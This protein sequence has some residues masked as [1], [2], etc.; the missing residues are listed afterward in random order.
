[1]GCSLCDDVVDPLLGGAHRRFA[2]LVRTSERAWLSVGTG[3]KV[4]DPS[5]R[6]L[7]HLDYVTAVMTLVAK[8]H[9]VLLDN[10]V[11]TGIAIIQN[12]LCHDF[13]L[14]VYQRLLAALRFM[15]ENGM[16]LC[17]KASAFS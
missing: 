9:S 5:V 4:A 12:I 7:P 6:V 11:D 2:G 16:L 14:S 17:Q 15:Q 10:F 13:L 8:L 3:N 1:M